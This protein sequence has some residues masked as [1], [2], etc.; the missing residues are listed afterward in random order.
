[1]TQFSGGFVG[2]DVFF[3]ISGFLITK[4][5]IDEATCDGNIRLSNFWARR[6]RRI[7]PMS[8]L[9]VVVTVIA[10]LFMLEPGRARELSTVALGAIGF[11]A[12]FVLY[13][14]TGNYLSGVTPPSPLQH[15]WSLAIEE[16]FY[17]IWPL[18]IFAVV[19]LGR[20]RWKMWLA[21][22]VAVL[23]G[24]SLL[25]SIL[26]TPS[27]PELGYYMPHSRFWEILAGAGL[28]LLGAHLLRIPERFRAVIGWLGL[29]FILWLEQL[30]SLRPLKLLG[31]HKESCVSLPHNMSERGVTRYIF[32]TGQCW[33]WLSRDLEHLRGGRNLG[34]SLSVFCSQ[35]SP[36]HMLNNRLDD[37][38]GFQ[39]GRGAVSLPG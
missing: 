36:I 27:R 19:K 10:G 32:G 2:V 16:Q 24:G 17:L 8:L 5:L 15:Y 31:D 37:K 1:M 34:Y 25:Y 26:I 11:C 33:Y 23:G 13:F 18:I 30:R 7:I 29:S 21:G 22:V 12:N 4:L 39:F 9:I 35:W 38:R 28:A 14:T 6:I 20:T 3:V